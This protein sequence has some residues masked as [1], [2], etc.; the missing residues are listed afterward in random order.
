[1]ESVG[2]MWFAARSFG[3]TL[4][5]GEALNSFVITGNFW[6]VSVLVGNGNES[7]AGGLQTLFGCPIRQ[8]Q[9]GTGTGRPRH[10]GPRHMCGHAR[11]IAAPHSR[12]RRPI[13]LQR[14]P[15]GTFHPDST[16]ALPLQCLSSSKNEGQNCSEETT[17]KE[18]LPRT[19]SIATDGPALYQWRLRLNRCR[20]AVQHGGSHTIL[21][22]SRA[23]R[24]CRIGVKSLALQFTDSSLS[25]D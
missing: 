7:F 25:P 17:P 11:L 15:R 23:R 13:W 19:R 1:M 16:A 10:I 12:R 9:C 21:R 14:V 6:Y 2:S 22:R 24:W 18:Y 4:H 3:V 5:T 8:Y 20:R